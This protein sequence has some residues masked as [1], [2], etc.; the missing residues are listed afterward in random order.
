MT[1]KQIM[2]SLLESARKEKTN[3][4][5]AEEAQREQ[6]MERATKKITGDKF[7]QEKFLAFQNSQKGN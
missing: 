5:G 3:D 2:S 1:D 7:G 4:D 6:T